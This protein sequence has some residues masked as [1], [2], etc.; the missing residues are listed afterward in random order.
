MESQQS[1]DII[2]D[3]IVSI[4]IKYDIAPQHPIAFS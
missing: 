3:T 2:I 1:L 4:I